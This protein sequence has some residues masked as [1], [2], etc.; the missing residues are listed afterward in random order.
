MEIELS[1]SEGLNREWKIIVPVEELSRRLDTR[2]RELRSKTNLR[3]FRPGKVPVNH[4]RKLYGKSLMSEIIEQVMQETG[5][6]ILERDNLRPAVS[7]RFVLENEEMAGGIESVERGE[8]KLAFRMALEVI[9][10][11][12]LQNFSKLQ[13]VRNV[14]RIRQ[15]DIDAALRRIAH[16]K[17]VFYPREE[18]TAIAH[19]GDRVRLDFD[20]EINGKP[21][22]GS[23]G[24]DAVIEILPKDGVAVDGFEKELLGRKIGQ[25]KISVTFP[26]NYSDADLAGRNADF[27]V[28]IKE[29]SRPEAVTVDEDFATGLG[30][31]SLDE[32]RKRISDA[33]AAEDAIITRAKLKR[34]LLDQ[35]AEQYTFVLPDALVSRELAA[36]TAQLQQSS[37]LDEDGQADKAEAD[38]AEA[39]RINKEELQREYSAIAERRVRLALLLNEIGERNNVRVTS[40]ELS[41]AVSAQARR[42]PGDEQRLYSY[43][44]E[45]PEAL[46]RLRAPIYEDKVTDFLLELADIEEHE[47]TREELYRDEDEVDKT[48]EASRG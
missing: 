26:Q 34:Q 1:R 14:A 11:I 41:H 19:E 29:I 9:P 36:I 13:L 38:K 10:E 6:Q 15:E 8:G 22:P 46:D 40:D 28:D 3:G 31:K 2:L 39:E 20:G 42:F 5:K 18:K 43:Y 23:K 35:L 21:F 16:R 24:R 33:L 17:R 25:G 48:S 47:V 7:P 44:R 37:A 32:L 4:L 12:Q 45:H 27:T 30:A